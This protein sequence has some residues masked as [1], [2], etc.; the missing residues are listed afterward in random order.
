[1]KSA[2]SMAVRVAAAAEKEEVGLM[3]IFY[4]PEVTRF[5]TRRCVDSL[6]EM[7]ILRVLQYF[8]TI[9]LMYSFL[10]WCAAQSSEENF[11]QRN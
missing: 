3:L 4:S 11:F 5:V 10:H 2:M 8:D 9:L 1:M 6:G 7:K